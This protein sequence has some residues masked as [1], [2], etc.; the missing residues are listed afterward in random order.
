MSQK[1][2]APTTL[3]V[4]GDC[5]ITVASCYCFEDGRYGR[6]NRCEITT[7]GTRI[8]DVYEQI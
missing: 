4:C 2:Q 6:T 1:R 5:H 3:V 7:V 8:Y